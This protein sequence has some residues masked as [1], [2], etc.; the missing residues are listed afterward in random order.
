[1]VDH[2]HTPHDGRGLRHVFVNGNKIDRVIYADTKRGV[3]RYLPYPVRLH[4]NRQEVYSRVLR[5]NV[6]V[7]LH[8]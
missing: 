6:E 5:G 1:M 7:A 4:R 3:V 8:G 2:I